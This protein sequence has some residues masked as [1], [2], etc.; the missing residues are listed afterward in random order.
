MKLM[1]SLMF[2]LVTAS[3]VAQ[4]KTTTSFEVNGNCEMCKKTI[5][6]AAKKAGATKA[7]WN[8]STH[9]LDVSFKAKKTSTEK[10]QQAIAAAGYDNVGAKATDAAYNQLHHCCKYERKAFQAATTNVVVKD[11]CKQK[12]A[13]GETACCMPETAKMHDCCKKSISEGKK[14]CCSN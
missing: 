11:C 4:T 9:V 7:V 6:K 14:A 3:V 2:V 13:K 5:E 10:I 12:L 1:I 8:M